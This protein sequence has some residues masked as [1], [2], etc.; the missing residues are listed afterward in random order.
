MKIPEKVRIG[1]IDYDVAM[2]DD[3]NEGTRVLMG[4]INY[5][6]AVIGLNPKC[7]RNEQ[8]MALTLWHEIIHGI[9]TGSGLP[10]LENEEAIV[11]AI[12]RGV[13]QVLQDNGAAF[14]DINYNKG[15]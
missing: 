6:S 9:I 15:E 8:I 13:Y 4:Q 3:L 1:G 2:V 5:Q 10:E 7:C 11:E 12:S 14:F